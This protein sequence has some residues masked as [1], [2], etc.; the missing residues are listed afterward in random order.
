MIKFCQ[1]KYSGNII[2]HSAEKKWC[3]EVELIHQ[4]N[5]NMN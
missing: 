4:I 1:V 3:K 5:P 2:G